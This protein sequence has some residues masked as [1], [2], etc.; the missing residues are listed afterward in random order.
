MWWL[1]AASID[2]SATRRKKSDSAKRRHRNGNFLR[3]EEEEA[4][5]VRGV[6]TSTRVLQW[7]PEAHPLK[8]P[9]KAEDLTAARR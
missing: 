8:V 5:T 1:R 7:L 3:M 9:R 2:D 6:Q 4:P